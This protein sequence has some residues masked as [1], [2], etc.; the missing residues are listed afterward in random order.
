MLPSGLP[1]VVG[2]E[3]DLARFL[4]QS[5]HYSHTGVRSGAFLP[6]PKD[7]STSVSRH[8]HQ[9]V[10]VLRQ[11]GEIAAGDRR[12]YGA[13]IFKAAVVRNVG[14][15]LNAKEPPARHALIQRWPW[16][17]HDPQQQKAQQKE[18]AL[19]LASAAGAPLLF[20]GDRRGFPDS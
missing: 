3:E 18:L 1:E 20:S 7:Q 10:E 13:A 4:T 12:L 2:D 8:G 11:L 17:E 19:Q 14:L 5:S 6:S 16:T 15:A 9:P